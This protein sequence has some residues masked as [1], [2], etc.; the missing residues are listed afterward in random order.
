VAVGRTDYS[1]PGAGFSTPL[2]GIQIPIVIGIGTL[3]LGVPLLVLAGTR[4]R[5]YFARR[6]ETSPPGL[7]EGEIEH[8]PA[9][10]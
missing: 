5:S 2:F 10:L 7:L 8:A 4:Y 6:P 1:Q 9:H 3:L